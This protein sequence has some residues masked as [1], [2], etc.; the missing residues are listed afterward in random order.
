MEVVIGGRFGLR[1][2]GLYVVKHLK[3]V[4][5]VPSNILIMYDESYNHHLAL[6]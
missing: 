5:I 3:R 4:L 1:K 6:T 2:N